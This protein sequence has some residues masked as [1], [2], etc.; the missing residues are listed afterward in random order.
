MIHVIA[1]LIAVHAA[2]PPSVKPASPPAAWTHGAAS[3]GGGG[4]PG[5]LDFSQAANSGLLGALGGF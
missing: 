3:G 1:F 2:Q 5:T 4:S